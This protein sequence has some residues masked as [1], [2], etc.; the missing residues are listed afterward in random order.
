MDSALKR[1][2]ICRRET[3]RFLGHD[4]EIDE[5]QLRGFR[6][7]DAFCIAIEL[8]KILFFIPTGMIS[9]FS[10]ASRHDSN[11]FSVRRVK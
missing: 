10:F 3:K 9:S 8:E 6:I 1:V 11:S 4:A 2:S 7:V 5:F